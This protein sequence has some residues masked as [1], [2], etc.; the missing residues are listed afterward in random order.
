ME[1]ASKDVITWLRLAD[2]ADRYCCRQGYHE[3]RRIIELRYQHKIPSLR[4]RDR[5]LERLTG[6]KAEEI[7]CCIN[8]YMAYTGKYRDR[9][10]CRLCNHPRYRLCSEG[11]SRAQGCS[12]C[13]PYRTF[14]YIPLLPRLRYQYHSIRRAYSL[15]TYVR[16]FFDAPI[17]TSPENL[18]N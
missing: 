18:S 4:R 17:T 7:D 2:W 10:V 8:S 5:Q 1:E 15:Q 11:S 12:P 6:I 13:E 9:Q 16:E 14:I 3:L